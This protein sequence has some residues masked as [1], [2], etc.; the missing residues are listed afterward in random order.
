M[1]MSLTSV[2]S[3]KMYDNDCSETDEMSFLLLKENVMI[4]K[5]V[6][7]FGYFGTAEDGKDPFE[8][9]NRP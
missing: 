2:R 7:G 1:K 5:H 3:I 6:F 8:Y 9:K 4:A